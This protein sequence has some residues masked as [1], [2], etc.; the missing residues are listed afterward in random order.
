MWGIGSMI[1][2]K[3]IK[4]LLNLQGGGLDNIIKTI[5]FMSWA[6]G[7]GY[8]YELSTNRAIWTCKRCPP[9]EQRVK[10]GKGEFPCKPTFDACFNNVI[11]VIDPRI[12]VKC[13]FCPPDPHPDDAWC[14][15]EFILPDH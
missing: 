5:N 10:I 13:I 3:R 15:W 14:Q 9:Q 1:E 2:A 7:F 8:E 4:N 6:P 11:N 12:S